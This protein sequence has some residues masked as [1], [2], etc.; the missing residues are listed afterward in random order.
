MAGHS[1]HPDDV[2]SDELVPSAYSD[3][4]ADGTSRSHLLFHVDREGEELSS[5]DH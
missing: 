1:V 4:A 5:D 3:R 2:C